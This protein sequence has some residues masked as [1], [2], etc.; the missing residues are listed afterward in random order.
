MI[1]LAPLGCV[2]V[3]SSLLPR[4]RGAAPI[5]WAILAGD[6][7]TGV[8]TMKIVKELDAGDVYQ[9]VKT[10]IHSTDTGQSV[11]DRLAELG[12]QL[13][14]ET[15]EKLQAGQTEATPQDGTQVTYASK[16]TKE[17][18]ILDPTKTAEELD[19]QVRALTPWP[20]TSLLLTDGERIRVKKAR[21]ADATERSSLSQSF[22]GHGFLVAHANQIYLLCREGTLALEVLQWEGKKPVDAPGFIHGLRGRGRDFPLSLQNGQN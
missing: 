1:R 20:G 18:E 14:I 17:M 16:L 7:E 4:W 9:Q 3:H 22:S 2:N 5:Q 19:R 21:L 11:H 10:P 15:F 12:A 8:S 6:T 13:L